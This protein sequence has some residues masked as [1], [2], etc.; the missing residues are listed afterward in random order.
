MCPS[1]LIGAAGRALRLQNL[2]V[3]IASAGFDHKDLDAEGTLTETAWLD[4]DS[5]MDEIAEKSQ[6]R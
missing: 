2:T 1:Y 3:G 5:S 6:E 4:F